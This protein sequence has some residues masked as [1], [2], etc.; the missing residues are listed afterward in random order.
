MMT[1]KTMKM[2]LGC[3]KCHKETYFKHPLQKYKYVF[4]YSMCMQTTF[5]DRSRR[6][7]K[8]GSFKLKGNV[9]AMLFEH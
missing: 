5:Y 6:C 3:F 2:K 1:M 4:T 8:N 9:V 7:I